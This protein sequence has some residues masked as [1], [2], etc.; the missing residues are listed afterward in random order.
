MRTSTLLASVAA[1]L[2]AACSD[3]SSKPKAD[4]TAC[5]PTTCQAAG[6]NCGSMPDGCGQVLQCGASCTGTQSCGGGGVA[7]VCGEGTCTKKTCAAAGKTCGTISDGCSDV[8]SCGTCT[9]PQSCGGGGVANV[10][11]LGPD[12]GGK[13]DVGGAGLDAALG[14]CSASCLDQKGAECCTK[15][16]CTATVKCTPVCA[17]GKP[18]DCEMER[19]AP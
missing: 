17:G 8:L 16:G 6:K 1:L 10:C 7:N 19:C 13:L 11:G 15:C 9:A 12:A 14:K 2:M 4:A 3:D 5:T 18:W